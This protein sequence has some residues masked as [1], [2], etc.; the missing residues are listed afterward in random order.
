MNGEERRRRIE[1]FLSSGIWPI[2]SDRA[3]TRRAIIDALLAVPW[4]VAER[5]L[6]TDIR[7]LVIAPP[8][9]RQSTV[10]PYVAHFKGGSDVRLSFVHF[11]A[12]LED[13]DEAT[14]V[15]VVRKAF[16]QALRNVA[17]RPLSEEAEW[18]NEDE[19]KTLR[20]RIN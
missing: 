16:S 10:V 18:A 9:A 7:M 13:L 19:P 8:A 14:V 6:F 1:E 2:A 5:L 20:E 17:G 4:I 11:E 3:K 15:S 12:R